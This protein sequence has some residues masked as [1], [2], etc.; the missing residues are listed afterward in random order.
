MAL[1]IKFFSCMSICWIGFTDLESS[2]GKLLA[3]Y[4]VLIKLRCFIKKP[5]LFDTISP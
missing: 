2:V 5:F 4:E 1:R 3:S